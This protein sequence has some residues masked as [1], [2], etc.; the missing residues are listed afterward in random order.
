MI[1]SGLILIVFNILMLHHAQIKCPT[2]ITFSQL[3]SLELNTRKS[4]WSILLARMLDSSPRL[5]ILK[6]VNIVSNFN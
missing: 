5:Q 1:F 2:G 4:E 6:L 3:V